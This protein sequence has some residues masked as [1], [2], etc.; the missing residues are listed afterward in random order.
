MNTLDFD[1]MM[2]PEA[3]GYEY[4]DH[5]N[6]YG[7][8]LKDPDGVDRCTKCRGVGLQKK[9]ERKVVHVPERKLECCKCGDVLFSK[10]DT[11]P[12]PDKHDPYLWF[13]DEVLVCGSCGHETTAGSLAEG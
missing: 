3:H 4:C 13:T 1:V 11:A 10:N 2:D 7:S 6:G 5:C 12:G 9:K 8:S